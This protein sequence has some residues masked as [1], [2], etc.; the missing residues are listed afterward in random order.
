MFGEGISKMGDLL[1]LG[2]KAERGGEVRRLVLLR[3]VSASA[4]AARTPRT[5]SGRI[6]TSRPRSRRW[7]ARIP[8]S[9]PKKSSPVKKKATRTTT[10]T[11]ITRTR[12]R[13]N[14][15]PRTSLE[16]LS[17]ELPRPSLPSPDL[18]SRLRSGGNWQSIAS[19][20]VPEFWRSD[21][22]AA[23]HPRVRR[24]GYFQ[25][26]QQYP[27]WATAA[28]SQ[29]GLSSLRGTAGQFTSWRSTAGKF[30]QPAQ[31]RRQVHAACAVSSVR[32]PIARED[33]ETP[34][35]AE[36]PTLRRPIPVTFFALR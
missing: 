27:P 13:H 14:A 20:A 15:P 28:R 17:D 7:S 34:A 6:P 32:A 16:C 2:V 8:A 35:R 19:T 33:G 18:I 36:K 31:Y 29:A 22:P 1:D 30:T 9:S 5:S 12:R 11:T 3:R 23:S 24:R 21:G 26:L 4:R 10:T 25:K